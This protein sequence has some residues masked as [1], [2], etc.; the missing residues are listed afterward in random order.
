MIRAKLLLVVIATLWLTVIT[1]VRLLGQSSL[2]AP[3]G[4]HRVGTRILPALVDESRPDKRFS[5]GFRTILV[6][7]W[8]PTDAGDGVRSLYITDPE[9]L[10]S[11]KAGSSKPEI[12]ESWRNMRTHSIENAP[13]KK[14]RF[15]LITFSPGFGMARAYYTSWIEELASDGFV[16]AAVD[17]PFVGETRIDGKILSAKPH[18]DGP[19]AQTG[20]MAADLRFVISHLITEKYVD[21]HRIAAIGHSIGGAAAIDACA[22]DPRIVSCVNLDGDPSFG[23]FANSDVGRPFLVIHQE[24]VFPQAKP[25][26][27]LYKIGRELDATWQAIVAR[28]SKPV[29]RLS[30]RGTAHFSFTDALFL[31]PDMLKEGS[32]ELTDP[33]LVLRGTSAAIAE[34]LRNSFAG[35]P[36]IRKPL[37]PFIKP[38]RLGSPN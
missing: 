13:P 22:L 15:P 37:P 11:L 19:L 9:L 7:L 23:K 32:A 4:P 17:H 27:E 18:P 26:D 30:V 1:P 6:Q 34:Y 35:R 29:L 12:V 10:D 28:Q 8:Y 36:A 38:A 14:G 31:R 33:L 20:A 21:A 2:P 25:G 3:N 24:P 16:V 5:G